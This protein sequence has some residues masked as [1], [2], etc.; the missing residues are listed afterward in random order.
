MP[1]VRKLLI[2]ELAMASH[3]ANDASKRSGSVADAFTCAQVSSVY[4]VTLGAPEFN[5]VNFFQVHSLLGL[6]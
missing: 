4:Q 2:A 5:F 3:S 1:A 6:P